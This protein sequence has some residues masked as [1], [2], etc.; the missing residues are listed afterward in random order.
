MSARRR[1][2][3]C[4]DDELTFPRKQII[5]IALLRREKATPTQKKKKKKGKKKKVIASSSCNGRERETH[6]DLI[7][8]RILVHLEDRVVIVLRDSPVVVS[9]LL[10]SRF[11]STHDN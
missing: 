8:S 2:E 6:S 10:R 11:L 3:R 1:N 9:F 7:G 4:Y 5:I